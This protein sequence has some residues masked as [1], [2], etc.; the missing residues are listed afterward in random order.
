MQGI[1]HTHDFCSLLAFVCI[2][3][4]KKKKKRLKVPFTAAN[5]INISL[6][7][8]LYIFTHVMNEQNIMFVTRPDNVAIHKRELQRSLY[9]N[10]S[11]HKNENKYRITCL[12]N[13]DIRV[14]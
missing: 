1:I 11:H 13:S 14:E 5:F 6:H 8:D 10:E 7:I 3:D 12:C 2:C 4:K 9:S